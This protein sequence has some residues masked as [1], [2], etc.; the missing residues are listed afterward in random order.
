MLIS[1]YLQNFQSIAFPTADAESIKQFHGYSRGV[2]PHL[3]FK[4]GLF[5]LT[6][7]L[8]DSVP[9]YVIR[10]KAIELKIH[11][12]HDNDNSVSNFQENSAVY[13]ERLI[14]LWKFIQLYEDQGY[15]QCYLRDPKIASML[16]NT[17]KFYDNTEY[18]LLAWTIMPNHIHFLINLF[19]FND[20]DENYNRKTISRIMHKIKGYSAKQA[21]IILGRTG[22][23]FW[24]KEYYDRYIRNAAHLRNAVKYIINNPR[25]IE[26]TLEYTGTIFDDWE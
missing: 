26:Y 16:I 8:Y 2:L 15:G 7:R 3:S 12:R 4:H 18:H 14:Q 10:Q 1:E 13:S 5:F 11:E 19:D 9:A 24:Q 21:N 22:Q 6:T 20:A 17:L 25:K 23:P